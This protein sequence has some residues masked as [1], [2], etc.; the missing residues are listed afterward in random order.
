MQEDFS[1]RCDACRASQGEC[2]EGR[3]ASPG[4]KRQEHPIVHRLELPPVETSRL[5][6]GVESLAAVRRDCAGG[7]AATRAAHAPR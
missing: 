7:A 3:G 6:S 1:V 4:A 5:E 2:M